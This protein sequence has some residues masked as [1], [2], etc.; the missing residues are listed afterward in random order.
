M[1]IVDEDY[2][3]RYRGKGDWFKQFIDAHCYNPVMKRVEVTLSDGT[4]EMQ[5]QPTKRRVFDPNALFD[6]AVENG[7]PEDRL[8]RFKE[9]VGQVTS[10]GR[11]RMSVGNMLRA[12]TRKNGGLTFRGTFYE[13]D[14]D[15][16]NKPVREL[17][18]AA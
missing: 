10:E 15:F 18:K 3:M 12:A 2:R 4:V 7:I 1:S 16:L 5:D 6:M 8:T 9:I 14:E 13:A 11:I 17:K